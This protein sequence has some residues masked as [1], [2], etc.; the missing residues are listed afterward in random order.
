MKGGKAGRGRKSGAKRAPAK[1][2]ARGAKKG[3]SKRG[4]DTSLASR[5]Q[6]RTTRLGAVRTDDDA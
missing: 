3:D 4:G 1:G 6:R 2:A 5:N